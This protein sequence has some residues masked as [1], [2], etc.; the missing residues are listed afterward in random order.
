MNINLNIGSSY[1]K[2]KESI[3]SDLKTA[4]EESGLLKDQ[5]NTIATAIT[6]N[7]KGKKNYNEKDVFKA[8]Q[9]AYDLTPG[10][11]FNILNVIGSLGV[12]DPIEPLGSKNEWVGAGA[13][14]QPQAKELEKDIASEIKDKDIAKIK[15]EI[16]YTSG[17]INQK[18]N[19]WG[20]F[21]K[22]DG[23]TTRQVR[24]YSVGEGK[25]IKYIAIN[26]GNGADYL[27]PK[28][29]LLEE[30][31]LFNEVRVENNQ[32]KLDLKGIRH[33]LDKNQYL[34]IPELAEY[35]P[36]DNNSSNGLSYDIGKSPDDSI[37]LKN[38][39]QP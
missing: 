39:L 28:G 5:A 31:N 35:A 16:E 13:R 12:N 21:N 14:S 25:N 36:K 18:I 24:L 30:L 32:P 10:K 37:N 6:E 7:L 20:V 8:A 29:E 26:H 23:D 3:K 19:L 22:S 1:S 15:R 11:N 9:I 33:I 27:I 38:L 2:S 34:P 4:L 17:D